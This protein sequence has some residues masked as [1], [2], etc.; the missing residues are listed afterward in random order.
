[1]SLV[2]F[3]AANHPQQVDRRRALEGVD[4]RRTPAD[5]VEWAASLVGPFTLDVAASAANAK[6][7][8][9]YDVEADG[10]AQPWRGRVWCNPPYSNCGAWV[11]KA[12]TEYRAGRAESIAM[13]LPANR[14]EQGWWHDSV[15]PYRDNGGPLAV[16]FLRGRTRFG[17]PDGWEVPAKGNRPPFGLCLL[18]W[19]R[20]AEA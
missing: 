1:M 12:W 9:F 18:L 7:R 16:R 19:G 14:T 4:E 20:G 15:E 17:M 8:E 6:C 3:R 5:I 11:N 10:L 2:G 13:L